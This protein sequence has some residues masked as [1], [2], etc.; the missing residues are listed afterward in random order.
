MSTLALLNLPLTLSKPLAS[1][2]GRSAANETGI[3]MALPQY[4]ASLAEGKLSCCDK[5][6]NLTVVSSISCVDRR[7]LRVR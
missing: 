1:K 6:V 5:Q 3:E 4:R 7:K 2:Y